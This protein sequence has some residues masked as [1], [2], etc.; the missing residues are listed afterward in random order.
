MIRGGRGREEKKKTKCFWSMKTIPCATRSRLRPPVCRWI[1]NTS[2]RAF[3][4]ARWILWQVCHGFWK[5]HDLWANAALFLLVHTHRAVFLLAEE[6]V[7]TTE[8]YLSRW[9]VFFL[10][11]PLL[12][13]WKK[14]VW[15]L[16]TWQDLDNN[17]KWFER[18]YTGNTNMEGIMYSEQ[19]VTVK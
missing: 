10:L 7:S 17:V 14:S 9:Y 15:G 13:G 18:I 4:E 19:A 2:R 8:I 5:W 11:R 3:H 12:A 6:C 16:E 1:S